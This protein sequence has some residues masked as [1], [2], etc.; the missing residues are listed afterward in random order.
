MPA[1]SQPIYSQQ[2]DMVVSNAA[3]IQSDQPGRIIPRAALIK[4]VQPT[5]VD[6]TAVNTD[7]SIGTVNPPTG[8]VNEAAKAFFTVEVQNTLGSF[9]ITFSDG[10]RSQRLKVTVI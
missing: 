4:S 2:P 10:T 5:F 6:I 8:P 3:P 1:G 9:I 7:A